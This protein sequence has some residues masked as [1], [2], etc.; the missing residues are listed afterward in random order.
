MLIYVRKVHLMP[1][2]KKWVHVPVCKFEPGYDAGDKE[3]Y[4]C[5]L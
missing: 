1:I 2:Q 4:K 3:L 5:T